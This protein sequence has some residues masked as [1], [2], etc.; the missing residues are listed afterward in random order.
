MT[1]S[2][3]IMTYVASEIKSEEAF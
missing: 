2:I 1:P 3:F